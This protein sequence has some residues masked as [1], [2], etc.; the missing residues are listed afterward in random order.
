MEEKKT[1]SG[2]KKGISKKLIIAISAILVVIAAIVIMIVLF[3]KKE[4]AYRIIKVYEKQGDVVVKRTDIGDVE[5]YENMVLESGDNIK[6]GEG[7]MTLKLDDDKYLYAEKNTEFEL[8]ASGTPKD[9]KTTINLIDGSIANEIQNKL[10]DDSYYEIN[11]PNSTMSV[12]GT[13]YYVSTYIGEDGKRY[14]KV[15]VFDGTVETNRISPQGINQSDNVMVQKGNEIIIYDDGEETEFAGGVKPID[16][17]DLSVDV[18]E[19]LDTINTEHGNRI[20]IP[21]SALERLRES[22]K[23]VSEKPDSVVA[24]GPFTV[25]F[26]FGNNE[27]AHQTVEAGGLV[28]KPTLQPA[29]SGQWD[30]DFKT[31]VSE[32]IVINWK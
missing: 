24:K 17:D 28:S 9:S 27:F 10:N 31:P 7:K 23:E 32:D 30:Y 12:R 19:L 22:D 20:D 1:V 11:T 8:I 25:T 21:E 29:E 26:M 18:I 5:A 4:E 6:V 2:E 3:S 14:T 15:S 16:Y 13:I